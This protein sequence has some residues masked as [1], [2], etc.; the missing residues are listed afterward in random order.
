[1]ISDQI[2]TLLAG[3]LAFFGFNNPDGQVFQGYGEGE[4]ILVAPQIGGTIETL[5]VVRGQTL[6][7]GDPLYTLEH[8]FEQATV[9][10]AK[11]EAERDEATLIDLVKAK[12][13]PELDQ[14][15]ASREQAMAALQIADITNSRDQ[16]QFTSRAISQATLDAD[17]ATLDQA[18]AKLAEAEAALATGRLST[19]RDDAIHAAQATVAASDAVLAAAQWKLD[20][21]TLATPTDAFVFDTLYRAGE[22]VNAG[23]AVVSLLPAS[24][25]RARF[26]VPAPALPSIVRGTAVKI[27]ETGDK[28]P[29]DAHITY[30]SP[31]AEYSPPELYNQDNRSKLLYMIEAT[32]DAEPE[33]IHPGQPIDVVVPKS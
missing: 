10:Q 21:K 13:Q 19:G 31:Q 29:I 23:Q 12:R 22:Y 11:A 16:K 26:F 28:T 3:F 25:I 9:N 6:H 17:K 18:H 27:Q 30:I 5:A 1:M 24:N 8:G 20:Q 2:H 33:R 32:P 7:K 4:Y 15:V 14:L